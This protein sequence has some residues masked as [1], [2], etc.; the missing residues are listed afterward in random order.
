MRAARRLWHPVAARRPD[1]LSPAFALNFCQ[2]RNIDTTGLGLSM[3]WDGDG[4]P[5]E[6]S[7]ARLQLRLPDG[8]PEQYRDGIVRAMA[9][10]AVKRQ[11]GAA[12]GLEVAATGRN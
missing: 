12:P 2:F 11:L 10:C 6:R 3:E 1:A 4:K 8:F 7:M 9:L 5:P